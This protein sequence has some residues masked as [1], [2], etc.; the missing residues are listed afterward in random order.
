MED[1]RIDSHKLIFHPDRVADWMQGKTVYPINAEVGLAGACNHRCIFC[2]VDYMGYEPKVLTR[3]IVHERFGEMQGKGLKSVLFA[4]TGEPLLNKDAPEII[5]DTKK[6]GIDVAL[7]TNGVLFTEDIAKECMNSISWIRFSTS[8]GTE[9]T[10]KTIHRGKDGDLERVFSNIYNAAQLKKKYNMKTVLGVQI[11]MIPENVDEVVMLAKKVKE[12]GADQ[13]SVKSFGWQPLSSSELKKEVDRTSYYD[14][15]EDLIHELEELND[16]NF[17]AVYRLNRM[18]KPKT[19]KNYTECYALPFHT[20]IDANGDVW[21]CCVLI[22]AKDMSFGNIYEN[23]FEEI[24]NGEQRVRV[25]KRLKD[26]KLSECTPEC[27]LDDMNRYLHELKHPN[28]HV[29]FI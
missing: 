15:R 22:G 1:Y 18:S 19:G 29:N 23:T 20:N 7:S 26:M 13:F 25:I 28:A 5:N 10:Y 4:G 6:M 14:N 2:A 27:K 12:L 3:R 24:W 16:E 8:A 21:P 9:E 11:V 17:R